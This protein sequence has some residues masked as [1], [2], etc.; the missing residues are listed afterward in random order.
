MR[1]AA[2]GGTSGAVLPGSLPP[3][4]LCSSDPAGRCVGAVP[5]DSR[6]A[7]L[8]WQGRVVSGCGPGG[9]AAP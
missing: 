6:L 7:P 5:G 8:L 3:W 9:R 4:G 1:P 2:W